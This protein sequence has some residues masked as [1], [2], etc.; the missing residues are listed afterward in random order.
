MRLIPLLLGSLGVA[1]VALAIAMASAA[2]TA[3][4]IDLAEVRARANVYAEDAAAFANSVPERGDALR[5]IA[6][7]VRDEARTNRD[8]YAGR[9][10]T[11][12][13]YAD[14]DTIDA[15]FNFD[16]LIVDASAA[17]KAS[18]GDAPRFVAFVSTS[19]PAASLKRIMADVSRAGGVVVFRGFPG[20]SAKRL[21]AALLNAVD[22]DH[23]MNGVG[24]DPAVPRL[25]HRCGA[26]LCNGVVRFRPL[27]RVRLRDDNAIA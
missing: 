21:V 26:R 17:E 27:R 15:T 10:A 12:A 18:F 6:A 9:L 4:N 3:P 20:N 11:T 2:Q 5:E 14:G 8:R 19:M 7:D 23:A 25:R 1:L 16:R 22:A 13:D 24:I